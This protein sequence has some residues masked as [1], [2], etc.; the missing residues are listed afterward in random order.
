MV[1]SEGGASAPSASALGA[2]EA[3]ASAP[4][5]PVLVAYD[6]SELAGVA[7]EQAARQL[8]A[9]RDALVVCVW[10]PAD[11]GFSLVGD[12]HLDSNDATAVQSAAGETA[13]YGATLASA[14]GFRATSLAVKA[15]PTWKGLVETAESRGASLIVIGSHRHKGIVGHLAGAVAGAVVAH[16]PCAVLVVGQRP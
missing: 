3:A 13:A 7:I 10:Q 16:A 2:T 6:G 12:R 4:A 9:G 5:G 15:A 1:P 8:G 14:A 11:V